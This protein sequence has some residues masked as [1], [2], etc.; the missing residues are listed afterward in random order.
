MARKKHRTERVESYR[1]RQLASGNRLDEP[2]YSLN[3]DDWL[4][5]RDPPLE[6]IQYAQKFNDVQGT[7]LTGQLK[8]K[9]NVIIDYP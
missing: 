4:E 8:N 6:I 3:L 1:Y 7:Y 9:G 2:V 5:N